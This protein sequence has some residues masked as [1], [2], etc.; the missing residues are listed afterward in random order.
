MQNCSYMGTSELLWYWQGTPEC[1]VQ[2]ASKSGLWEDNDNNNNN[3]ESSHNLN[4]AF[5]SKFIP[6]MFTREEEEQEVDVEEE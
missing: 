5:G 2:H 6:N 4:G 1:N 3:D